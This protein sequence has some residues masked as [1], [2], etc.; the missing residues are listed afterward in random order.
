MNNLPQSIEELNQLLETGASVN[1]SAAIKHI[2]ELPFA[3]F[4]HAEIDKQV[5]RMLV[6]LVQSRLDSV[7]NTSSEGVFVEQ[8]S[9]ELERRFCLP[10]FR[11]SSY[12]QPVIGQYFHDQFIQHLKREIENDSDIERGAFVEAFITEFASRFSLDRR[13]LHSF[14][15]QGRI[16]R[17]FPSA[18]FHS[19]KARKSRYDRDELRFQRDL[20]DLNTAQQTG[21]RKI[22][23]TNGGKFESGTVAE[24]AWVKVMDEYFGEQFDVHQDM[25]IHFDGHRLP[26]FDIVLSK[27]D[28]SHRTRAITD[29]VDANDVVAAF[30]VKR[31]L[32][33]HHVAFG[34]KEAKEIFEDRCMRLKK[35]VMPQHRFID[36]QLTPYQMLRGKIY[37]G[38]LSLDI[39]PAAMD[40]L[41]SGDNHAE[42]HRNLDC[43]RELSDQ[44]E[45]FSD[46]AA[47][48]IYCPE[49]LLWAKETK[50]MPRSLDD[51][52]DLYFV[53]QGANDIDSSVSSFGYLIASMRRF[54]IAQG[55]IAKAE[56]EDYL[57][58]YQHFAFLYSASSRVRIFISTID[59]DMPYHVRELGIY[60]R[61][62]IPNEYSSLLLSDRQPLKAMKQWST[63]AAQDIA[64]YV[65]RE[66]KRIV[67]LELQRN[68]LPL[69]FGVYLDDDSF[70]AYCDSLFAG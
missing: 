41:I 32:K 17:Y 8:T 40:V 2:S 59:W 15:L 14:M 42:R 48:I 21:L 26:K 5:G 68:Y 36:R 63:E 34:A 9:Q 58:P 3:T 22:K 12:I 69:P 61:T 30:E 6:V 29:Y 31:T 51:Q 25:P 23:N 65:K 4:S 50:L 60:L 56:R 62:D 67:K 24:D 39:D 57:K 11:L 47:D 43:L 19:I 64:G 46:Y 7:L 66:L 27:K 55:H 52:Q 16:N 13:H 38:V 49:K 33:K 54:F 70:D 37:F 35:A 1:I 20:S 44:D 45:G 28:R 53:Q 10:S 18:D